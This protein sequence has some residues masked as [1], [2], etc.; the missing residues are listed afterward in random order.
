MG[1]MLSIDM[2]HSTTCGEEVQHEKLRQSKWFPYQLRNQLSYLPNQGLPKNPQ[3]RW[4][5][6]WEEPPESLGCLSHPARPSQEL[7]TAPSPS[8]L[9]AVTLPMTCLFACWAWTGWLFLANKEQK[10]LDLATS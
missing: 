8:G 6:H 5:S 3:W 2:S 9:R 4:T 7:E 10:D 1:G